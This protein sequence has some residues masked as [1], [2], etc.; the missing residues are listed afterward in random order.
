MWP[1]PQETAHW[2]TL[3]EGIISGKPFAVKDGK[4]LYK[5]INNIYIYRKTMRNLRNRI[6]I[7]LVN[8]KKYYLTCTSEPSCMSHKIFV[9]KLVAI[10]KSKLSLK[11]NKPGYNGVSILETGTVLVYEF[12]CDFIKNKYED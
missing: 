1:N 7:E 10:N 4:A 6:Y 12:Y 8:N 9:N 3:T 5:L 2:V 11:I